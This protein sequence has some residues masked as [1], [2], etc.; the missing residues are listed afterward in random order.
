MQ[1]NKHVN[2]K[3][4]AYKALAG[5]G[6][7]NDPRPVVLKVCIQVSYTSITWGLVK[8]CK[9]FG[10]RAQQSEGEHENYCARPA[11]S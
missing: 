8:K 11:L 6:Y 10:S 7:L 5:R 2:E 1:I 9:L 4:N 3:W